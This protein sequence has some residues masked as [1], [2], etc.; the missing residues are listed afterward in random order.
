MGF[1]H[2]FATVGAF[3]ARFEQPGQYR[4]FRKW[5]KIKRSSHAGRVAQLVRAPASHLGGGVDSK[6]DDMNRCEDS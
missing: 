6:L 2:G 5:F 4:K 3:L 1:C